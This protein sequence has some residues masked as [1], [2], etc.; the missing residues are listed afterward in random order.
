MKTCAPTLISMFASCLSIQ[1]CACYVPV[2]QYKVLTCLFY[3][4]GAINAIT[5]HGTE[6]E[7]LCC[8]SNYGR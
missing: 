6:G 2:F 7:L 5:N 4:S 3:Q 8:A 1:A